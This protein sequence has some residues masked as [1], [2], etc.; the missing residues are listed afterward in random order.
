M[1]D[2]L[3][4]DSDPVATKNQDGSFT[5][6]CLNGGKLLV[7]RAATAEEAIAALQSQIDGE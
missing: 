4:A 6:A 2:E 1:A 7:A 5:A 3:F